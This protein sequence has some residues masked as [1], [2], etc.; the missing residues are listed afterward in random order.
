MGLVNGRPPSD[1]KKG[2][3]PTVKTPPSAP[4]T[5]YPEPRGLPAIAA[6]D[7]TVVGAIRRA[8]HRCGNATLDLVSHTV[9]GQPLQLGVGC[10][11]V[12]EP[13]TLADDL[14]DQDGVAPGPDPDWEE[15]GP[16]VLSPQDVEQGGD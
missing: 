1:P 2:A 11:V 13:V 6:A 3:L 4:A 8:K 14:V 10:G 12:P 7:L 16:H 9:V 5:Q 15:A